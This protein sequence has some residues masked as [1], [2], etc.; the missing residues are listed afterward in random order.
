MDSEDS[1]GELGASAICEPYGQDLP[2]CVWLQVVIPKPWTCS[3]SDENQFLGFFRTAAES[4]WRVLFFFIPWSHPDQVSQNLCRLQPLASLLFQAPYWFQ[5]AIRAENQWSRGLGPLSLLHFTLH[6]NS[7]GLWGSGSSVF[8]QFEPNLPISF[9][10]SHPGSSR[11][12]SIGQNL[13][14]PW[15]FCNVKAY[16]LPNFLLIMTWIPLDFCL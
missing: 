9:M 10:P 4:H 11:F 12:F 8:A 5:D 3:A 13:G 7:L 16:L 2:G 15:S 1:C 6:Y 14:S